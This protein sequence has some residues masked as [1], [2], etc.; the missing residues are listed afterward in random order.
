ML[1]VLDEVLGSQLQAVDASG[2]QG[3]VVCEDRG[4]GVV[5]AQGAVPG[6]VVDYGIVFVR[7]VITLIVRAHQQVAGGKG[8][9]A[10]SAPTF[11]SVRLVSCKVSSV[12]SV[13]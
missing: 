3:R 4:N 2:H 7:H 6:A 12:T 13:G 1:V 9:V 8:G 10:S 11:T 5:A